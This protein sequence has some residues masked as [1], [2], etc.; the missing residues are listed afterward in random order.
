[1]RGGQQSLGQEKN[2]DAAT[3]ILLT[4]YATSSQQSTYLSRKTKA[5]G[6]N[7]ARTRGT[8]P[9]K[10]VFKQVRADLAPD[11]SRCVRRATL[12]NNTQQTTIELNP[13]RPI[14]AE[15]LHKGLSM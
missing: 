3:T 1:M 12:E 13:A 8:H 5:C 4:K 15:T 2:R 6:A 9:E 7:H 11:N 14:L 10:N